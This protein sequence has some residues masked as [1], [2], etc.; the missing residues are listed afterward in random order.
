M[1][2]PQLSLCQTYE[3]G[4]ISK[5]LQSLKI[6]DKIK[7]KGPK[8]Q[9]VYTPDLAPHL[10]MI[11]GGTGITPMLQ[12]IRAALKNSEDKTTMS[13]IYAN[14]T[15]ADILLKKE[16]DEQVAASNGRLQVYHVLNN[17]PAGWTQGVGFVSKEMIQEHLGKALE[18]DRSKLL[19]CGP[20]PMLTAMKYVS[21]AGLH[22]HTYVDAED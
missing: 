1:L 9:M 22:V 16:L 7:V 2:T 4:N 14:V 18:D 3:K 11:A 19:L 12:I 21:R 13:L 8:G 10:S 17:P 5:H 20:P 15:E 6:G